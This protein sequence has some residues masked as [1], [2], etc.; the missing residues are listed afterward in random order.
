MITSTSQVKATVGAT[1]TMLYLDTTSN[2]C[3]VAN[4]GNCTPFLTRS[5]GDVASVPAVVDLD[6]MMLMVGSMQ[7]L[8]TTRS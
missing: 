3:Y 6:V 7:D 4:I 1:G 8:S 5:Q 2:Q